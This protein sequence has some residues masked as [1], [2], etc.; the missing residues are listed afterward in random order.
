M[1]ILTINSE[2]KKEFEKEIIS[3]LLHPDVAS[4]LKKRIVMCP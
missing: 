4:F 2:I 1:K 3:F